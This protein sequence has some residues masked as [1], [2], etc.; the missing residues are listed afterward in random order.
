[1]PAH[2]VPNV[3]K[4][5]ETTNHPESGVYL[6]AD[7]RRRYVARSPLTE[8]P[9]PDYF[10]SLYAW[11]AAD[12]DR[13]V[14]AYLGQYDLS[15]FDAEAPPVKTAAFWSIVNANR[16]AG[17]S[18]LGD[19]I[20]RMEEPEILTTSDLDAGARAAGEHELCE[21][22]REPK[23]RRHIPS[24]L[25]RAGYAPLANP[26]AGDGRWLMH[27]RKVSIYRSIKVDQARALAAVD[28][29][30]EREIKAIKDNIIAMSPRKK[31]PQ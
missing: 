30:I 25:G 16:S 21:W 18:S 2:Y 12:G 22:L 13:H 23:H 26:N 29:R 6:E 4:V 24:M 27:G 14:A 31:P 10:Q 3:C 8:A 9:R 28:E 17:E 5:V 15:N 1:M 11:L 20:I 19:I 7:D